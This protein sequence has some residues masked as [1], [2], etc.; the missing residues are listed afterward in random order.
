M[1][2]LFW[3]Q[4]QVRRPCGNAQWYRDNTALIGSKKLEENPGLIARGVFVDREAPEYC[5]QYDALIARV[6]GGK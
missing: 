2:H 1:S 4:E 6:Q 3:P 5:E